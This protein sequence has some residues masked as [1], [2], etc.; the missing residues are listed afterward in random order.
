MEREDYLAHISED[1]TRTQT[2]I[3]HA[4]GVAELA[5]EFAAI[6]DQ[7]ELGEAAG[8]FH[9][10]GK[11]TTAFANRL[12]HHGPKV[13]HATAGA[14]QFYQKKTFPHLL[15]SYCI[16]G[17]HSGLLDWGSAADVAGMP[18]MRG[19]MKKK[20]ENCDAYF[21]GMEIPPFE[22]FPQKYF[23]TIIGEGGFTTALLT[24]MLFSCLVDAD[25]L[26][27]EAFM[28]GAP[29][30]N[31]TG[32]SMKELYARL[33]AHIAP[34]LENKDR[35]TINGRRTEILN[36][37][38]ARGAGKQGLYQLT[39]PTGGGKT[40]ASLA[41]GLRHAIEH[42]LDRI[43]YVIPY[44][45]IIEQNA[46][47]FRNI[48][49]EGNVLEDHC[50]VR[51]D[52]Y[53]NEEEVE[54]Q[55]LAAENYDKRIIVT[56]NV[57]FFESLFANKPSKCRKLHNLTNSVII[58][59]EA[60]ML[61]NDYLLPCVRAISELVHNYHCT[62]VLCTATQPALAEFFPEQIAK[63]ITEICPDVEGQYAFFRRSN[64]INA[65]TVSESDLVEQVKKEEQ[66]LCILNRKRSVKKVFELISEQE[67]EGLYHLSTFMYPEHRKRTL[68]EIRARLKAG[69]PCRVI[70]TSLIEA[71]VDVDFPTVLRELSGIDSIIQAAG[72]CNREGKR[73]LED[74]RTIF[75]SL[76]GEEKGTLPSEMQQ[77]I[78]AAE[79]VAD[80]YDDISALSAIHAYFKRLYKFRGEAL[81]KKK[82]IDQFEQGSR[83]MQ[84]PFAT[85]AKEFRLIEQ[86]T[87][88]VLIPIEA[89]A[90][91]IAEQLHAGHYSRTLMRNAGRY[92]VNVYERDF[93]RLQEAGAL[94]CIFDD[95]AILSD[96]KSQYHERY[97]LKT[98]TELGIGNYV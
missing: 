17:H 46:E 35:S 13:D 9:D 38:I 94:T 76:E 75:F 79:S 97:G 44:T 53:E 67:A 26:D 36:A 31:T 45:S 6:F 68:D 62:A 41:F 74:S 15:V 32:D 83:N 8:R 19:R 93:A 30:A 43:I 10:G 98:D 12:L 23:K 5:G 57:Q 3:Q 11:A 1:G 90:K 85:V 88:A 33:N 86:Q 91:A 59:D 7:R 49:G 52:R 18:T 84:F 39:V 16:A 34:W 50:N 21:E 69:Q 27:T 55:Q 78:A 2:I 87:K 71:G 29:R 47:V 80:Q 65:G 95:F 72:R 14:K 4:E 96:P 63:T 51:F 73:P 20:L 70:A 66:I 64:I 81:D 89:E 60:Q 92:C 58:F 48:V 82:V 25:Y 42:D 37:C 28:Q 24:R 56:T 54:L 22:E 61:P 40:V 77:P